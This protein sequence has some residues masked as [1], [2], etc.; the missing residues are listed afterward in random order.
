MFVDLTR[1]G[2]SIVVDR[3]YQDCEFSRKDHD[4]LDCVKMID[5]DD[6]M[7]MDWLALCPTTLNYHVKVVGFE[8]PREL[9]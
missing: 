1:L 3:L 7:G 9:S 6:I 2:E 4:P 8:I 5:F